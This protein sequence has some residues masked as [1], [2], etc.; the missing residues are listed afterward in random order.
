M[1]SL[2][3]VEDEVTIR[4]ML[5]ELFS[6]E[7]TC[8]Q[9]DTAEE[10]LK[11]LESEPI[12]VVLTDISMPGMSGLELLGHTRQRWPNTKVIMISGIRDREY[13]G[14]LVRM[15]AFDYLVKPF[16]LVDIKRSVARATEK[17]Q[18]PPQGPPVSANSNTGEDEFKERPVEVFS[19]IQLDKAFPLH[20][21]LE[22]GQRNRMT[23]YMKLSWDNTTIEKA[24][25]MGMFKEAGD[26]FNE[27]LQS[28]SASIYLRDGLIID[29][30]VGESEQSIYWSDAEEALAMLVRLAT[31]VSEGVCA[32]GY[33]VPNVT[34]PERLSVTSNSG[35]FLSI[36]A[37][38]EEGRDAEP[39]PPSASADPRQLEETH[40]EFSEAVL[41]DSNTF[42]EPW[43]AYT[44]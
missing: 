40:D 20:E 14:G 38:D 10:A 30:V 28:Q 37:S 6:E 23:G 31:W 1:S 12:D 29:A 41:A 19:S 36:V 44:A 25:S 35:K 4:E 13:A 22:M 3:I 9:T 32:S 18:Q 27:A 11:V 7:H 16:E 5:F 21:L 24:R 26:G 39:A 8:F 42:D 33:T 15:G 34:R 2:L 17:A 43:L